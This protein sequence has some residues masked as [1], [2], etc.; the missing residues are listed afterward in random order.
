MRE[1]KKMFIIIW[2]NPPYSPNTKTNIGNISI[3]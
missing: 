2:D 3:E 1:K